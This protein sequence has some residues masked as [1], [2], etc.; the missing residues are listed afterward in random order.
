MVVCIYA[1]L[2]ILAMYG[3]AAD[4]NAESADFLSKLKRQKKKLTGNSN[5]Q[6]RQ[7]KFKEKFV[8]S[9]QVEKIQFGMSNFIEKATPPAFQLYCINRI[10]D[11]LL[12][13]E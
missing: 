5:E 3:F 4:V 7:R 12:V 2:V 9:C 11:L 10:V 8:A 6:R 13:H 1:T